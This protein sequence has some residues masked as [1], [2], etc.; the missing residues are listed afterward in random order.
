MKNTIREEMKATSK[1][2]YYFTFSW[3]YFYFSAG[4]FCFQKNFNP[5]LMS[6]YSYIC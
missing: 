5:F 1:N 2:Y 6:K 4:Y 3:G